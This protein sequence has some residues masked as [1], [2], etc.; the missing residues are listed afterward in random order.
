[1]NIHGENK[2]FDV[3]LMG[4]KTY[5]IGLKEGVTSPY[6]HLKQYLFSRTIKESPDENVELVGE[7]AVGL[8]KNLKNQVGKGIWLCG[9]GDLA[10]TF[11]ANNLIDKLI[12][13]VNPFLM[14]SGIPLFSGVIQQTPL[15]LIDRKIYE[16]GVVVL[17]YRVE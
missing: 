4:R 13:K 15:E 5:E 10:T 8:V 16:N 7:N 17:H 2:V 11:F 1:M 3:V 14:G 6:S 12:L 9:G